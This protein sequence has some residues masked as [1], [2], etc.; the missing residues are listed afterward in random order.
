MKTVYIHGSF[1][2]NNFG[3]FLLYK[4][5]VEAI[6]K[7]AFANDEQIHVITDSV[8][9]MYQNLYHVDT[10]P[11][12]KAIKACDAVVFV[13]G[14]Y[15]GEPGKNVKSWNKHF[16]K[17]HFLPLLLSS[18][19]K[20]KTAIIGVGSGPVS[21]GLIKY[22]IRKSIKNASLISVR[23]VESKEFLLSLNNDIDIEVHPDW[24]L[25][26][27]FDEFL[28][29]SSER[30]ENRMFIHV[31]GNNIDQVNILI[32]SIKNL[33][34]QNK[35]LKITVGTDNT[36]ERQYNTAQYIFDQLG[37]TDDR[38][39]LYD[40]PQR[41]I[42]E[43]SRCRYIVTDKLHVGICGIRM[44]KQVL[45][46]PIHPKI[47]RFYKQINYNTNYVFPFDS[48]SADL[49]TERLADLIEDKN[50]IAIDKLM[51]DADKNIELLYDFL[52]EI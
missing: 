34:E 30:E 21:N 15:L 50:K 42:S 31:T 26:S 12:F 35:D 23:D 3:D 17:A 5:A 16:I 43:L 40:D 7:Y 49:L 8:S 24:V 10:L 44:G 27:A 38:L 46:L 25:S 9:N 4:L 13:G 6:K 45:S 18:V 37:S 51:C 33:R 36:Q 20:R 47:F 1:E 2:S 19:R 39:Y 29:L 41:L 32:K 48:I 22:L 28:K 52:S 11:V 14:G